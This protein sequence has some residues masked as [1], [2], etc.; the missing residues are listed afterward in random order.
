MNNLHIGHVPTFQTFMAERRQKAENARVNREAWIDM[1]QT[2][3]SPSLLDTDDHIEALL[4]SH[5]D[6]PD[7]DRLA[8]MI[9]GD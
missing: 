6:Y 9:C 2:G 3:T 8:S 4:R 7:A 1:R 5:H